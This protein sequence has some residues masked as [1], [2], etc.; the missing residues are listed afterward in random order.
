M[1]YLIT[2]ADD[3]GS[4]RSANQAILRAVK[5]GNY[6]KNV[7]CM[8]AS[9]YIEEGA[10]ELKRLRRDRQF[11]IGLHV[12]LNS[13][14]EKIQFRSI[15]PADKIPSLVNGEGVF[16][17]HPMLFAEKMPDVEEC[18]LEITAQLDKL[19]GI[20]LNPEY[21]DTHMLPEGTVPGL[22]DGLTE[23]ANKHG[24]AEQRWFYTFPPEHQPMPDGKHTLEEDAERYSRWFDSMEGGKQY[25]NILHP[26][27]ESEETRLF[28]NKVLTGNAVALA[29]DAEQRLL[30]SGLLEK[31]CD[32]K[33]ITCLKY[34][35]AKPQGDTTL[36]AVKHF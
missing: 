36:D 32:E 20:G 25:I 30:N 9:S 24:L 33:Q 27:F 7:S 29:R 17:M 6:L 16:A 12:V 34:T 3:F 10:E 13:E 8:A 4:A 22:M 26:A 19:A 35:D 2:R 23:F 28:Y 15:L 31:M 11:C 5:E 21:L 1:R 18:I 14:W